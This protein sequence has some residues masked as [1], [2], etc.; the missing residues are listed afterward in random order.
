[1]NI[2]VTKKKI[3]DSH[4]KRTFTDKFLEGWRSNLCEMGVGGRR[5][6][7]EVDG[8]REPR[9]LRASKHAS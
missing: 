7:G 4:H 1:M 5:E 8:V 2:V 6:R 9:L 3:G